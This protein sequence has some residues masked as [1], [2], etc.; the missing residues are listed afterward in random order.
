MKICLLIINYN[1]INYLPFYMENISKFCRQNDIKLIITDDSSKDGSIQFLQSSNYEY[2]INTGGKHGFAA[3]INHGIRYALSSDKFDYFIISN[4]DIEI[5]E[6]LFLPLKK[7]LLAAS[8]KNKNL[9]LIGFDEINKDRYTYFKN[10]DFSKYDSA[11]IKEVNH[12]PGFF[13]ILSI[14]LIKEIGY[15]N[16]EYFMYGEDNDYWTRTKKANFKIYNSFLPVMHYSEG[17]STNNKLTSW[18]VYRNSFLFAQKNLDFIQTCR[19]I[20]SFV[21]I[22]Y[23]PFYQNSSPSSLRIKRNGFL[24]NNYLLIRSLIWNL[25]YFFT[26]RI[27][28]LKIF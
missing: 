12:I 5:S 21:N 3:N 20:L 17:S 24:Y 1:G 25:K 9:G 14:E 16:E 18:Y 4:N 13:F 15:F 19:L 7:T 22:I 11:T 10:F 2:T 8:R 6:H 27:N 23:N 28:K 26:H